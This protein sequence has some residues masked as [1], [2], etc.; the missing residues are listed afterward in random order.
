MHSYYTVWYHS[1]QNAFM[2]NNNNNNNNNDKRQSGKCISLWYENLLSII[3]N[4]SS[5]IIQ[6]LISHHSLSNVSNKNLQWLVS[7]VYV[8]FDYIL[9]SSSP[10]NVSLLWVQRN[11]VVL[12]HAL[13]SSSNINEER[14]SW[15]TLLSLRL[16]LFFLITLCIAPFSIWASSI[17]Q[18]TK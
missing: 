18:A 6:L 17:V 12:E 5:T 4:A 13:Q 1:S 11:N 7:Y 16:F 2:N 14:K 8:L 9:L 15:K 3:I 10:W